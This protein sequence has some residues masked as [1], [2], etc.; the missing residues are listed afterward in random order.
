MY[1]LSLTFVKLSILLQYLRIAT[2]PPVRLFCWISI[3]FTVAVCIEALIGGLLQC[4]PI[5]KFWD[6]R[7]PGK[8][9]NKTAF[10]YANAAISIV[11]DVS[12]VVLPFFMLKHLLMP[13]KEKIC[14]MIILG[15]GGV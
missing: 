7:I 2:D 4:L 12:L 10:Y 5:A 11:Q 1:D 14:L 6:D 13:R 15:F 8:C 9:I 3:Y